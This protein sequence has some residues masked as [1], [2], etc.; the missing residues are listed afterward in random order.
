MKQIVIC[1]DKG[2]WNHVPLPFD[3]LEEHYFSLTNDVCMAMGCCDCCSMP[4]QK[5]EDH[6]TDQSLVVWVREHLDDAPFVVAEIPDDATDWR[7]HEDIRYN[8]EY[9]EY[10][11]NGKIYIANLEEY[12]NNYL[13]CI[14]HMA[15]MDIGDLGDIF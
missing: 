9:I 7:V 6:R 12:S 4:C 15:S 2:A 14:R 5:L 13:C 8:E 1:R 10:V 3:Y 11:L